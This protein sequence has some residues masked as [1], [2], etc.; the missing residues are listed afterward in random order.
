MCLVS[1][2]HDWSLVK[3]LFMCLC[4]VRSSVHTRVCI[5]ALDCETADGFM[6]KA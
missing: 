1:G 5:H 3:Y 6:C 2:M 4:V